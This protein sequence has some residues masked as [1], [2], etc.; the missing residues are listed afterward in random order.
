MSEPGVA[1]KEEPGVVVQGLY[2]AYAADQCGKP[3]TWEQVSNRGRN[4]SRPGRP[5]VLEVPGE[6]Q[7]RAHVLPSGAI[8]P[9]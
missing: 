9:L 5:F 8:T 2:L 3:V 4:H 7:T 1:Q 6:R